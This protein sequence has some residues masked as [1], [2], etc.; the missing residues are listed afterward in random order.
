MKETDLNV[1]ST[2]FLTLPARYFSD[3]S[4][5]SLSICISDFFTFMFNTSFLK[6]SMISF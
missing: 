6:G 1:S 2:A 5:F 3:F 4:F